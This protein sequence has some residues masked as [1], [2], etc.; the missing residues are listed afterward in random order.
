MSTRSKHWFAL[1]RTEAILRP[2]GP[3]AQLANGLSRKSMIH[4]QLQESI[5]RRY[6]SR[7]ISAPCSSRLSTEGVSFL[8]KPFRRTPSSP[9]EK[10]ALLAL[11]RCA[12]DVLDDDWLLGWRGVTHAPVKPF[13]DESGSAEVSLGGA[14]EQCFGDARRPCVS[15][16]GDGTVCEFSK[17][18]SERHS[19]ARSATRVARDA[20]CELSSRVSDLFLR[21]HAVS[22]TR[23]AGRRARA[24]LLGVSPPPRVLRTF[25]V[26]YGE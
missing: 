26:S 3:L 23:A 15:R 18:G 9:N 12:L 11:K 5:A 17:N 6:A 19:A 13:K 21:L 8:R 22:S 7:Y 1:S 25:E 4:K 20:W 24:A 16:P 2:H 10:D 14:R